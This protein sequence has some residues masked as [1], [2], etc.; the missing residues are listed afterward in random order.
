MLK[1]SSLLC[2]LV[3]FSVVGCSSLSSLDNLRKNEAD[4]S[5]LSPVQLSGNSQM[6]QD[7]LAKEIMQLANTIKE[8]EKELLSA[9]KR[10][11]ES[12]PDKDGIEGVI[13]YLDKAAEKAEGI[14]SNDFDK[15]LLTKDIRSINSELRKFTERKYKK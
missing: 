8:K 11:L 9:D 4:S 14:N 5:S 15:N 6:Q 12:V 7:A 3:V 10:K 13:L 2:V 1:L